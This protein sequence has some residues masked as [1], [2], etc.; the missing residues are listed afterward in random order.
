MLNPAGKAV[1]PVESIVVMDNLER[2]ANN[3]VYFRSEGDRDARPQIPGWDHLMTTVYIDGEPYSVD[4]RVKLVEEKPGSGADN[5]LYYYSPEEILTIEKV[6]PKT[7]TVERRAL[8]MS[9]ELK[10]TSDTIIPSTGDGVKTEY[11]QSSGAKS[12]TLGDGDWASL[13][14]QADALFLAP[15]KMDEQSWEG[16]L[17]QGDAVYPAKG[18]ESGPRENP[19]IPVQQAAFFR[20]GY[21]RSRRNR[22]Y[23][24][25]RGRVPA[26]T[27]MLRKK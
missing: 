21:R 20:R 6:G 1:P 24:K 5:V 26:F 11:A 18:A 13:A 22:G 12:Q 25:G 10:P 19:F 8:N 9:S 4:M 16:L 27:L 2:I 14:Q 7:P 3:G 23:G 17:K 15:P